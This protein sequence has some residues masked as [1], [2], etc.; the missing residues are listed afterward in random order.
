[1]EY[2]FSAHWTFQL[3]AFFILTSISMMSAAPGV[4]NIYRR[5]VRRAAPYVLG[6]AP[7]A[8]MISL[9]YVVSCRL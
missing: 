4:P 3:L 7:M 5:L 8:A 6:A 2:G 9:L 1:M